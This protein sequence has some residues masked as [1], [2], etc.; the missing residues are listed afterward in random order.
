VESYLDV[1]DRANFADDGNLVRLHPD[2]TSRLAAATALVWES[3]GAAPLV[4][5]RAALDAAR[6][7][8]AEW[9]IARQSA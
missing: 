9:E 3:H 7:A 4:Q 8:V 2:L 6:A 5:A 1:G